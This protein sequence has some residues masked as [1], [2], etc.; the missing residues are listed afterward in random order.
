LR[1]RS[2]QPSLSLLG[3]LL[4]R[5]LLPHSH[6]NGAL[7]WQR[8]ANWRAEPMPRTDAHSYKAIRKRGSVSSRPAS[9]ARAL[10]DSQKYDSS[11]RSTSAMM[12]RNRVRQAD[13]IVGTLHHHE[14]L[15]PLR[16]PRPYR[17]FHFLRCHRL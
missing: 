6:C 12:V 2:L 16:H 7:S 11:S 17:C 15:P 13:Q 4:L 1:D 8:R 10:I 5:R 9:P 14:H 3:H